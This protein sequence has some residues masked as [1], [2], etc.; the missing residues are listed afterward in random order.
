MNTPAPAPAPAGRAA[1]RAPTRRRGQIVFALLAVLAVVG[2]TPLAAVAWK[3]IDIN[4]EALFTAHQ[5]TQLLLASSIAREVGLRVETLGLRVQ[6]VARK[7]GTV[8]RQHGEV[9][10]GEL[11][12]ELAGDAPE[13]LV[14]LRYSAFHDRGLRSVT[15]GVLPA[16]LEAVLDRGLEQAA[17]RVGAGPDGP[18]DPVLLSP[19]VLL[20]GSATR[21]VLVLTAPI[22]SRGTFRGVVTGVVDLEGV[23]QEVA[24]QNRTGHVVFALDGSG[25]VFGST[26]PARVAPGEVLTDSPL[27]RRYLAE[28]GFGRETMTMPFDLEEDGRSERYIGSYEATPHGWGVF[29]QAR[30]DEIYQPVEV[31]QRSAWTWA[32]GALA[33]AAGAALFFARTLSDPINRLA[34]ASRA[35]ARG[36]FSQRVGVRSNNEIGELADTFNL[37]AGEIE[38]HI[39]RLRQAAEENEELFLGTIRALAQAIDAK[40]PYTRGHSGRVNRYSVLLARKLGLEPLEI[41]QIHVASLLHDVGKIGI[42]DAILKKPGALTD[43]EFAVMKTHPALGANIMAPIRQMKEML[44]GLRWHHERC[45][46]SGYPDGLTLDRTPLMAR[47]IAV[48]DTFDAITTNRPYQKRMTLAQ[49]LA[50]LEEIRGAWLDSRIVDAFRALH[51]EGAIEPVMGEEGRDVGQVPR[52]AVPA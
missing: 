3:L 33:L 44:P 42:D 50:R 15:A 6:S 31:M 22:V 24:R 17:E 38:D 12:G 7:L 5:E 20:E 28:S 43:E 52:A 19:P 16:G 23:W 30:Q 37:M 21:A 39:R 25:R 8:I 47:I 4:R 34:A 2:L 32:L 48:A 46:G 9:G 11:E 14:Y 10:A 27:V 18:G 26:D 29:V 51:A 49:A 36:D 35:F 41:R 45:N 13:G 40:D 1:R